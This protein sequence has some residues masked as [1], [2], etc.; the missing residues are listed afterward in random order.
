MLK[1]S[2][3]LCE[4]FGLTGSE[5]LIFIDLIDLVAWIVVETG[6]L[7]SLVRINVIIVVYINM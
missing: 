4:S 2:V 1:R 5:G 7:K 3:S 6:I